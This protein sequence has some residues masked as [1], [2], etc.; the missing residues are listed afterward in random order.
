MKE[1]PFNDWV[2]EFGKVAAYEGKS[3]IVQHRTDHFLK[4]CRVIFTFKSGLISS[5]PSSDFMWI[6]T[7]CE[8]LFVRL[9]LSESEKQL[10]LQCV[11]GA[12]QRLHVEEGPQLAQ[13]KCVKAWY[14]S[15]QPSGPPSTTE[16]HV[17]E[18]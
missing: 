11:A 1:A 17:C 2:T 4:S 7:K 15:Q 6:V 8:G 13:V 14:I 9:S 16:L 18:Q 3:T 12:Q 5:V 10:R